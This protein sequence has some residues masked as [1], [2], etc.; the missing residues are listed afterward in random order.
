MAIGEEYAERLLSLVKNP[1]KERIIERLVW[2]Y[3]SHSFAIDRDE[4]KDLRLPVESLDAKDDDLLID[5]LMEFSSYEIS[6]CGFA[7]RLPAKPVGPRT[8]RTTRKQTPKAVPAKSP[9]AAV[10]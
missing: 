3:P 9:T 8:K 5:L 6:Y 2:E 7:P 1:N 10:A 4:A